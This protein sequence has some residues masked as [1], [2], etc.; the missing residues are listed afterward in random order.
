MGYTDVDDSF[1]LPN[2][3][4]ER[5]TGGPV[6]PQDMDPT[7]PKVVIEGYRVPGTI[8]R[9]LVGVADLSPIVATSLLGLGMPTGE[10]LLVSFWAYLVVFGLAIG[11]NG[12][13]TIGGVI[14][15]TMIVDLSRDGRDRIFAY[16][17]EGKVMA[18]RTLVAVLIDPFL[19]L[20]T[21]IF[22]GWSQSVG[23]MAAKTYV[24]RRHQATKVVSVS[25][26]VP[27]NGIMPLP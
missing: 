25:P 4:G 8:R 23:D 27:K 11:T 9:L 15:G 19:G 3:D 20:F 2:P 6:H 17:P 14:F 13:Y 7:V 10:A 12:R 26:K 22:T 1:A 16:H 18:L 21:C 24:I 5:Y